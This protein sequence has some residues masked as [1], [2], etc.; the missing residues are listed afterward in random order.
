MNGRYWGLY[1]LS[2]PIDGK[3]LQVGEGEHT[4]SKQDFLVTETRIDFDVPAEI[5]GYEI[6]AGDTV[7]ADWAG[8]WAPLK[9][10]YKTLLGAQQADTQALKQLAD[11]QSAID[12]WLFTNLVQGVDQ[13]LDEGTLYNYRLTTKQTPDGVR[14]LFTPWDFDLTWGAVSAEDPSASLSPQDHVLM[15][16]NPIHKLL[17]YGDAE[18]LAAV[19][20]R[21]QALRAGAWSEESLMRMLDE[22]EAAVFASGAY[23]RDYTRWP[24]TAHRDGMQDLGEFRAYVK[25]RLAAMD[26]FMQDLQNGVGAAQPS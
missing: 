5:P 12:C 24:Q 13:V 25:A 19:Q 7:N 11:Q 15:T 9:Q 3:Q 22:C 1:A 14:I 18:T 2:Y 21:Y 16:L 17:A 23:E 10:Y 20:Q 6:I 26:A 4:F 8:V